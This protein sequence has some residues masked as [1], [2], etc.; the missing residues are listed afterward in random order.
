MDEMEGFEK[1]LNRALRGVAPPADFAARTAR[2]AEETKIN[3][4]GIRPGV[5]AALA[6]A[7]CLL[8]AV[9]AGQGVRDKGSSGARPTPDAVAVAPARSYRTG[10]AFVAKGGD[11]ASYMGR[12]SVKIVWNLSQNAPELI[13][14]AFPWED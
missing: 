1:E 10:P 7:A 8:V 9:I 4:A 2:R 11:V 3:P 14:E 13:V 5:W 6:A 12:T